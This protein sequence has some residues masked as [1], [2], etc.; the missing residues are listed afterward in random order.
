MEK[1][2][3][4]VMGAEVSDETFLI[5]MDSLEKAKS[6]IRA[7][8]FM[9]RIFDHNEQYTIIEPATVLKSL[10]TAE[11][12]NELKGREG[13]QEIPIKEE[14]KAVVSIEPAKR[15]EHI[16]KGTATILYVFD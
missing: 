1:E 13:V 11:L 10:T 12:F 8:K 4:L 15:R 6:C 2:Y 16:L 5:R 9:D 7:G 3:F 14:E